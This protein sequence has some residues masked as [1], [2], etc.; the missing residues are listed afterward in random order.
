MIRFCCR[1]FYRKRPAIR[2]H[3][4]RRLPARMRAL[5]I[6]L[7]GHV[8][9]VLFGKTRELRN[10]VAQRPRIVFG[11]PGNLEALPRR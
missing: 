11:E 1:S 10:A 5:L 2:F 3:P 9:Y 4:R 6:V 8:L 7:P